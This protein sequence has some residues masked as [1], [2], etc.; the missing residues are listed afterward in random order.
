MATEAKLPVTKQASEP[1]LAW[2]PF[3]ALRKEVDRLFDDF[4]YGA[5]A[6]ARSL[7]SSG[8]AWDRL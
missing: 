1:S 3:D 8:V 5:G 2:R 4:G 7:R 6:S